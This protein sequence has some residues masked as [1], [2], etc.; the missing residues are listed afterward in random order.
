MDLRDTSIRRADELERILQFPSL[1][2]IPRMTAG[3]AAHGASR[4]LVA[5]FRRHK[6]LAASNGK[7]VRADATI[8]AVEGS[9]AYAE[10]Y[11]VLGTNLLMSPWAERP[12]SVVVTSPAAGEGKTAVAANLAITLAHAGMRVLLVDCDLRR[13]RLHR[14]FGVARTPGL[15]QLLAEDL[16][17]ASA[18]QPTDTQG[19]SILTVGMREPGAPELMR[20]TRVVALLRTLTAQYDLVILDAPPVLS[21]ADASVISALADGVLLVVRAGMT[22]RGEVIQA[23]QQLETVGAH[24]LGSVLNDLRPSDARYPRHYER[25]H[26]AAE[27]AAN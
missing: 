1:A 16:D 27:S 11:R 6:Q 26:H 14:V 10:A 3:P 17:P 13:A 20:S 25:Y 15:Q 24:V 12:R 7:H 19:L 18:I 21:V 5:P 8:A 4:Q 23:M 22:A 9:L 2:L